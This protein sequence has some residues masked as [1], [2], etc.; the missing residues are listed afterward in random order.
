MMFSK[1]GFFCLLLFATLCSYA[2]TDSVQTNS[3]ADPVY[4]VAKKMPE[5]PGGDK[6]LSKYILKTVKIPWA[7]RRGKVFVKVLV[8]KNGSCTARMMLGTRDEQVDQE[9]VKAVTLINNWIPAQHSGKIVRAEKTVG[10][11]IGN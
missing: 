10:I 1:I 8:E 2:Q 9:I 7:L 6:A 11:K 5:Y 3:G 4:Y